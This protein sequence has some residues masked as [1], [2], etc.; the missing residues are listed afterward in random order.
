[1]E[2]DVFLFRKKERKKEFFSSDIQIHLQKKIKQVKQ[3][4][5][6]KRTYYPKRID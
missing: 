6:A 3:L 1:M 4:N 5:F 2:G